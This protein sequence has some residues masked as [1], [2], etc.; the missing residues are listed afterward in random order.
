[1]DQPARPSLLQATADPEKEWCALGAEVRRRLEAVETRAA[2][3]AE[4]LAALSETLD[5]IERRF[6]SR[7]V[8]SAE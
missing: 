8:G 4:A 2:Q 1:M 3:E 6:Q 5:K 7:A